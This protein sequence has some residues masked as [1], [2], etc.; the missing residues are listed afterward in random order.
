[1]E[2][3]RYLP[4]EEAFKSKVSFG[5]SSVCDALNLLLASSL[6]YTHFL[7]LVEPASVS[8]YLNR[9]P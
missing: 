9:Y 8:G 7:Y 2:R 1:M 3:D 5:E 6:N 4:L